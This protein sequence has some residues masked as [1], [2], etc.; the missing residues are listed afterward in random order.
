MNLDIRTYYDYDDVMLVPQ[1]ATTKIPR[2]SRDVVNLT[3]TF[4]PN[5]LANRHYEWRGVPIMASNMD[6]I[7]TFPMAEALMEFDCCVALHKY[8]EIDE[9]IGFFKKHEEKEHLLFYTMGINEDSTEKL[10]KFIKKYKTPKNICIDV[11]NGYT[12]RFINYVSD[13]R[14]LCP[15]ALIMAGNVVSA[16]VTYTLIHAGASIIK[17]G[18]GNGSACLTRRMTGVGKP[19]FSAVME[20]ANAAHG[21]NG[22]ICADGGCI[23][24]GDISKALG[25]GA[26]FVMLGGMLAGHDECG[27][28]IIDK[29]GKDFMEFYGMSSD[30]AMKKYNGGVAKYKASE[31]R[32]L[33]VPYKGQVENTIQEILGGIR[34]TMLYIGAGELKEISKCANFIA[35][36]R[37]LNTSLVQF[38]TKNNGE[39]NDY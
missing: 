22:L 4:S 30:T 39:K 11:A 35:H 29:G 12:E 31:G 26:D 15:D 19:Q 8:Y 20:C 33:L 38:E 10:H 2:D 3:R 6:T 18:I 5:P 7:G 32:T 13:I 1:L 37:Q 34:S 14:E 25:G 36:S 27:G 24:P 17:V 23:Y 16:D 9:L 21:S 28:W